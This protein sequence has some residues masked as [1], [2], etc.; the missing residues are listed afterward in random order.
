MAQ[1]IRENGFALYSEGD[2]EINQFALNGLNLTPAS[3]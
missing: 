2:V 3:H 1:P